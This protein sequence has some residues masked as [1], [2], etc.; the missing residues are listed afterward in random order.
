MGADDTSLADCLGISK[1]TLNTWKRKYPEFLHS[2]IKNKEK[3]NAKVAASLYKSAV[4]AHYVIEEKLVTTE[5]GFEIMPLK[6]QFLLDVTAQ[7]L[8]LYNRQPKLW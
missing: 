4:S 8:W 3:A 2:I 6:R 5:N 7:R 1:R